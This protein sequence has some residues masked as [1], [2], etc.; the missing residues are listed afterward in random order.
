MKRHS[1]LL[2]VATLA[3]ALLPV[4]TGVAI[5]QREVATRDP[6][7]PR[8]KFADSLTSMNDRCAVTRNRLNP[9]IRP[10][11]VNGKPIGFC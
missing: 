1:R 9:Q 6:A 3:L 11:Y 8:L 4:L 5:A 2:P 10:I 7:K